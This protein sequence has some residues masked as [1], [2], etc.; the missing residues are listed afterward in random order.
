MKTL[1]YLIGIVAL[2][3][4]TAQVYAHGM[5]FTKETDVSSYKVVMEATADAG[6]VYEDYAIT[7]AFYLFNKDR[8]KEIVY[9]YAYIIFTKKEG[10]RTIV[11]TKVSAPKDYLPGA[12]LD[13]AMPDPGSYEAEVIFV[14]PNEEEVTATFAFDVTAS[15]E[16][17]EVERKGLPGYIWAVLVFIVGI[18]LGRYGHKIFSKK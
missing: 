15:G 14:L 3:G 16:I 17:P 18:A 13:V 7:Y 11:H 12:E 6:V 1:R 8:T 5:L 10:N 9:D 2:V 4:I